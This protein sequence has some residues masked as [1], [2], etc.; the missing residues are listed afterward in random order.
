MSSEHPEK[1]KKHESVN[2]IRLKQTAKQYFARE[3]ERENHG[4]DQKGRKRF[5]NGS[6]NAS[7]R[8]STGRQNIGCDHRLGSRKNRWYLLALPSHRE[9]LETRFGLLLYKDRIIVI[10]E[11]LRSTIIAM[12]HHGHVSINKVDKSA[13]AFWW[14]G[15]HREIRDKSGNCPSYRAAGKILKTQ[16]PQSKVNRFEFLTEPGQDIRLEF[17]GPIKSKSRGDV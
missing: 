2:L 12:L 10:P 15:L 5:R 1:F 7:R 13:E 4:D 9:H 8:N 6:A 16:L 14:P 11:A 3:Q 17:A